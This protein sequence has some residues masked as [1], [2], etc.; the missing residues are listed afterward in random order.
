[1]AAV[2][3]PLT[4]AD[5]IRQ[6]VPA[7]GACVYMGITVASLGGAAATLRIRAGSVTGPILD[8]FNLAVNDSVTTW[9]GPQGKLCNGPL[10]EDYGTGTYEGSVFVA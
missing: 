7:N 9:Y 8:S 1:M 6:A 5:G 4:G 2:P 10:F 3:I